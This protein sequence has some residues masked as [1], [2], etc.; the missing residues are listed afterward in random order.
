MKRRTLALAELPEALVERRDFNL[1][2]P[3]PAV[4]VDAGRTPA[5][6]RIH[7]HNVAQ[8][9]VCLSGE[10]WIRAGRLR[11]AFRTGIV[12]I[13]PPEVPHALEGGDSVCAEYAS[14]YVDEERL[15]RE[16]PAQHAADVRAFFQQARDTKGLLLNA[17]A[18]LPELQS[19]LGTLARCYGD[20][21]RSLEA[22]G[23]LL[24]LMGR[25]MQLPIFVFSAGR[26]VLPERPADGKDADGAAQSE[27]PGALSA[28]PGSQW[29]LILPAMK[30]VGV[31]Y[32]G[33]IR[34]A[35]MAATCALSESHFRS[36]FVRLTGMPPM[37]F[38]A[39][40]RISRALFLLRSTDDTVLEIAGR[41][42]FSSIA[43]F[44]RNFRRY[45]GQTPGTWRRDTQNAEADLQLI[46]FL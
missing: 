30:Y 16:M 21:V 41:T 14:I 23:Q 9:S 39:R 26:S 24:M 19:A 25:M 3:T 28:E 17:A 2:T 1:N 35:D 44:N 37:D 11:R 31:H 42:G 40:V 15:L 12:L 7:S 5:A 38:V 43:T 8:I 6:E 4:R 18:I 32:A 45:V 10:G 34:A 46:P 27:A 22:Y 13:V 29:A 20:D 33:E 36:L